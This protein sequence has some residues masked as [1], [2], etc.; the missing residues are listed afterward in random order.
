MQ[1]YI[2]RFVYFLAYTCIIYTTYL[3]RI[4]DYFKTPNSK[5]IW[6]P[7]AVVIQMPNTQQQHQLTYKIN[8]KRIMMHKNREILF[9]NKNNSN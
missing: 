9:Y 5:S 1:L 7:K 3:H 6:N 8:T 4:H 2:F